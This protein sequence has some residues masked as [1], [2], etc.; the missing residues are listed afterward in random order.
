MFLARYA[1]DGQLRWVHGL[2]DASNAAGLDL[3]I[4]AGG[5][6]YVTGLF[7]G[8]LVLDGAA[9]PAIGG[10]PDLFLLAYDGDGARRWFHLFPSSG[11][12]PHSIALAANG[13]VLVGGSFTA[14]TSFGG[15]VINPDARVRGFMTR[16]RS[17]GLYLASSAI[18]PAAPY[19]SWGPQIRVGADGRIVLQQLEVDESEGATTT[20]QG[21]TLRVLDPNGVELWS[22][23]LANHGRFSPQERA[24]LTTPGG[25]IATAA[26]TDNPKTTIG[27]MEVLTFAADG[28]STE[29]SFGNRLAISSDPGTFVFGAAVSATGALAFTGQFGGMV[30][31]GTGAMATRGQS[32]TDAFVVVVDP[33]LATQ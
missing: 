12:Y 27:N 30:D 29:S 3:A 9:Y 23:A 25:L 8:A 7:G 17:D 1:S 21:S 18:G 28:A 5:D 13:D 19:V 14:P 20:S 15:A 2:G 24:L 26:W 31:L 4:D 33:P 22:M 16:F 10:D 11:V 6:I 32:D